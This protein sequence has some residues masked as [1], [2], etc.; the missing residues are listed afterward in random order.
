MLFLFSEEEFSTGVN[1]QKDQHWTHGQ[2]NDI[3]PESLAYIYKDMIACI[4][5]AVRTSVIK[6]SLKKKTI[7]LHR[8]QDN[9]V[10]PK[11]LQALVVI[12]VTV[13]VSPSH[14]SNWTSLS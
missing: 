13:R 12:S 2:G 3:E 6:P 7:A 8:Q 11:V 9:L 1:R 10:A 4:T 14:T 5:S